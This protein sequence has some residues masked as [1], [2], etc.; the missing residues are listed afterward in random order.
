M[1]G[2]GSPEP[3]V[4]VLYDD[5]C[6]FCRWSADRLRAWD[7]AGRLAF[8][9]IGDA[10]RDGSLDDID[11]AERR[12]SWHAVTP[13]GRLW[14]A[15][16]A[17]APVLRRLPGGVPIAS[18]AETFPHA[19]ERAYRFVAR[20]RERLGAAIGARACAVDPGRSAD[21]STVARRSDAR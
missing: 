6:G 8:R 4:I 2:S 20:H 9:S 11:P 19:T 12:A 13:D 18:A 3:A 1:G 17:L 14:S 16:A 5:D 10:E 15:G 21:R 7:R